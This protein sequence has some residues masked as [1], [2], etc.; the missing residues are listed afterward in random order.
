MAK[1]HLPQVRA[2]DSEAWAL[3]D[4]ARDVPAQVVADARRIVAEVGSGGDKALREL[5]RKFDGCDFD[6]PFL[7]KT[8][9]DA[10]MRQVPATVREAI[11]DNLR[12]IQ[13]FHRL[14]K[15]KAQRL[16]VAPGVVLGRR[17]VPFEAV[18][19]FVPGG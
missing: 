6:D 13:A 1:D 17:P 11:D 5:T 10:A 8:E 15:G 14:Q 3:A 2:L 12:R 19:C 18:A 16:E 7:P 9:W 4:R